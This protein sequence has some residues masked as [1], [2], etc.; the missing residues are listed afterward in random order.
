MVTKQTNKKNAK[1]FS[2]PRCSFI[3][4]S[5][6]GDELVTIFD[7]KPHVAPVTTKMRPNLLLM[8]GP[9]AVTSKDKLSCFLQY[10]TCCQIFTRAETYI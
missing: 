2:T 7:Y 9:S 4:T 6:G 5:G 8:R 3:M 10:E 1:L